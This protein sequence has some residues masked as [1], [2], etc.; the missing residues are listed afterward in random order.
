MDRIGIS[1]GLFFKTQGVYF[2]RGWGVTTRPF[3]E[4]KRGDALYFF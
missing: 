1:C 2:F 4:R 3:G